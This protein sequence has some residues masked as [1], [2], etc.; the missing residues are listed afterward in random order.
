MAA[1]LLKR[2]V[3]VLVCPAGLL[4]R[5]LERQVSELKLI[6]RDVEEIVLELGGRWEKRRVHVNDTIA[7]G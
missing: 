4:G 1:G 3:L 5:V 6:R 2:E 7:G